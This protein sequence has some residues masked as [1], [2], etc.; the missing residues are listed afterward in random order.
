MTK[1]LYTAPNPLNLT[2]KTLTPTTPEVLLFT[3]QRIMTGLSLTLIERLR[4][5]RIGQGS[6][7]TGET[8]TGE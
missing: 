7:L 3:K 8:P 2:L 6:M 5:T 1:P 4:L